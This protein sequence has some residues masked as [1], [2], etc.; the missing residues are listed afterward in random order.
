MK[1]EGELK[2]ETW[3]IFTGSGDV[4]IELP[5]GVQAVLDLHTEFGE[6]TCDFPVSTEEEKKGRLRGRLGEVPRAR[7][8]VETGTGDISLS[9][10]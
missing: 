10:K 7:I 5:E 1:I 3:R 9:R 4:N 2:E 8:Q 6:I